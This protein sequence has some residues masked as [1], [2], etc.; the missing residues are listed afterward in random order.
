MVI[1]LAIQ[2]AQVVPVMFTKTLFRE[3][4]G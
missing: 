4:A 1:L 3:G 2:D